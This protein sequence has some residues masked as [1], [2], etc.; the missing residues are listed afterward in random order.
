[1]AYVHSHEKEDGAWDDVASDNDDGRMGDTAAS[2][3]PLVPPHARV[4]SR[5]A[6]VDRRGGLQDQ[7]GL[8]TV[9]EVALDS[10]WVLFLFPDL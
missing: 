8:V 6:G 3:L 7:E 10:V 4:E 1:V 2:R 5:H 9:A